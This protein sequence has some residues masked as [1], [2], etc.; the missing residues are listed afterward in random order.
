[1]TFIPSAQ[2]YVD[3]NNTWI[4]SSGS[5]A[6]GTSTNTTGYTNIIISINADF[7]ST[8]NGIKIYAYDEGESASVYYVDSYQANTNYNR[9]FKIIKNI[10]ILNIL[11]NQILLHLI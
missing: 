1:M 10:I 5:T 6:T 4:S 7:N 3:T 9:S 11:L 8:I 2:S